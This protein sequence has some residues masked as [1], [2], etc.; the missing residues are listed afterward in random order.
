[1]TLQEV[2]P[3]VVCGKPASDQ[4]H[5]P[6][7][8][9]GGSKEWVGVKIWLCRQHHTERHTGQLSFKV[10]N[11]IVNGFISE[12]HIFERALRPDDMSPDPRW[13]SDGRLCAEWDNAE[14]CIKEGVIRQCRV[15]YFL[16]QRYGWMP[17]WWEEAARKLDVRWQ[18]VY[19]SLKLYETFE[20]N[21]RAYEELGPTLGKAVAYSKDPNAL[22]IAFAARDDGHNIRQSTA[23]VKAGGPSAPFPE[24]GKLR[25]P[26][27]GGKGWVKKQPEEQEITA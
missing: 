14:D 19:D 9:S 10:D 17:A 18:R 21:W 20:G 23:I 25:C 4:H 13:W 11:G 1:M 15:A 16:Q 3:C 12:I 8:Q 2:T 26:T 5:E 7:K 22:E 24:S 27:C 6:P